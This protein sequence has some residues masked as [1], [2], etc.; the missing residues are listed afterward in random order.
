[1]K[2][3]NHIKILS[4]AFVVSLGA[5]VTSCN[6]LD[7]VPPEQATLYDATKDADATLGFLSSCYAGIANPIRT[8]KSE[9]A[10]DEYVNPPLWQNEGQRLSYDQSNQNQPADE[11]WTN[12][13]K[14]IGQT[15]L[16]LQELPNAAWYYRIGT[17][18]MDG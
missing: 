3:L 18:G 5:T 13:Y 8:G 1:M 10:A 12:N 4:G 11:R 6:F 2:L 14:F 7:I 9:S 16:F 15:L 17:C